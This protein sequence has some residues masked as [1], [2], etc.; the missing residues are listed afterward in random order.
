M[1]MENAVLLD[2]RTP[3]EFAEGH[4]DGAV[5]KGFIP[6]H[7]TRNAAVGYD[8]DFAQCSDGEDVIDARRNVRK[9]SAILACVDVTD[10]SE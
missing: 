1:D 10:C 3:E 8:V 4:L 6:H 9:V 5:R 7:Q 2:V